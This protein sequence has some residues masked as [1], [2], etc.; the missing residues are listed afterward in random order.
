MIRRLGPVNWNRLHRLVYVAA[1]LGAVHFLMSV[2]SWPPEPI[3]YLA[4]V[5]F[6]V[7]LRLIPQRP[8]PRRTKA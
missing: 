4:I 1:L 5:A 6:L 7:S 2:K 3:I 8:P